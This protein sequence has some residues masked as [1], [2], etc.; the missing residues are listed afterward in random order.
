V[1]AGKLF[2]HHAS[3]RGERSETLL[4]HDILA[5][6]GSYTLRMSTLRKIA[7][8]RAA[9]EGVQCSFCGR[10]PAQGSA[11]VAGPEAFICDECIATCSDMLTGEY[12]ADEGSSSSAEVEDCGARSAETPGDGPLV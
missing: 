10:A 6:T 1:G 12:A 8:E 5:R 2:V 11:L 3:T 7:A 4:T 9:S